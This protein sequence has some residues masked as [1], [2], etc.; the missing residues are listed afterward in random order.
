MEMMLVVLLV[1]RKFD[2]RDPHLPSKVRIIGGKWRGRQLPV[3][4]HE[5]LRPTSDRIRET[6]FNWLMGQ[7]VGARC[8]DLFA[9][10]GA[11]GFEALSRGAQQVVLI[12]K[13][14]PAFKAIQ[15]S[16]QSLDA[17]Q[18]C[19]VIQSDALAFLQRSVSAPPFDI[20]F[21]DPPFASDLLAQTLLILEKST[22]IAPHTLIYIET[23][24][25]GTTAIPTHWQL[26]KEKTAGAVCYRLFQG[27]MT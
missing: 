1:V 20:I 27:S 10:T 9:G 21:L 12:E 14:L 16:I 15:N 5:S 23:P 4:T 13:Y 24:I 6:L 25:Q 11:L 26:L 17:Q 7:V 18:A 3:L 19:E 8:L 2:K 22:L